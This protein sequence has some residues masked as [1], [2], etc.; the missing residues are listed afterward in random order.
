MRGS[1]GASGAEGAV[2]CSYVCVL[3]VQ[4]VG[5]EAVLEHFW[6]RRDLQEQEAGY[7][8]RGRAFGHGTADGPAL[9][10]PPATAFQL[11]QHPLQNP[12]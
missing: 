5:V 9:F 10:L 12:S 6:V 4:L 3:L 7:L 2:S 11:R 1:G 8:G